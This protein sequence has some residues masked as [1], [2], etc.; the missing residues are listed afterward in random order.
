MLPVPHARLCSLEHEIPRERREGEGERERDKVLC[1]SWVTALNLLQA[2]LWQVLRCLDASLLLRHMLPLPEA[3]YA[4]AL[5]CW[6][7]Q[8]T[9]GVL[10]ASKQHRHV[11]TSSI[12]APM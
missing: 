6:Q 9:Q 7:V 4:S 12:Q 2:S 8:S 11:S 3:W 1:H 10:Q 5:I